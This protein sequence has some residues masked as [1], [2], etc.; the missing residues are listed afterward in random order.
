M[1]K[2]ALFTRSIICDFGLPIYWD[3][4]SD[5]TPPRHTGTMIDYIN[6]FTAYIPH[7]SNVSNLHET[8]LF[9]FGL[10][11]PLQSTVTQHP[12]QELETAIAW[13]QVEERHEAMWNIPTGGADPNLR[14]QWARD[15]TDGTHLRSSSF[16]GEP[17]GDLD[18]L[19]PA[20]N[21]A[22]STRR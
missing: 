18:I 16:H 5:L 22:S 8:N 9:T 2:W 6:N 20:T 19:R 17:H 14:P 3:K 10:Q 1:T 12:P 15:W 7:A 4:I 21:N 13:A 11:N